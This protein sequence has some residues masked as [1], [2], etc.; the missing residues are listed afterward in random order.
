MI[1]ALYYYSKSNIIGENIGDK[2]I[3]AFALSNI[4]KVYKN[5]KTV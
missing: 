2:T 1:S 4:G 3:V 5:L